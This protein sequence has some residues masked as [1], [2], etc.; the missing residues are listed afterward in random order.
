M[1]LVICEVLDIVDID[2]LKIIEALQNENFDD[3]NYRTAKR[4]PWQ[5]V[6]PFPVAKLKI[7]HAK[8]LLRP[9]FP[10]QRPHWIPWWNIAGTNPLEKKP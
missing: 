7:S 9:Y 10:A 1:L 8:G 6:F 5:T 3:M 4:R 2:K